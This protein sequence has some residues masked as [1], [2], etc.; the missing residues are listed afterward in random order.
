MTQLRPGA[1]G[2][3]AP[4]AADEIAV[5]R[6]SPRIGTGPNSRGRAAAWAVLAV[7]VVAAIA[8]AAGAG[9]A[10][11]WWATVAVAAVA[12]AYLAAIVFK[13]FVVSYGSA[14]MTRLGAD[15]TLPDEELPL[16]TV[17]VPLAG[18]S[19][20]GT[21][22]SADPVANLTADMSALDY[23]ADRLQVLL[24]AA[25]GAEYATAALPAHFEI[26]AVGS[27]SQADACA[28]GLARARGELCVVYEPGQQPERGQLRAAASSFTKL[29]AWV[30]G[31]RPETQT[32]NP[33]A[34]W[35][36][37]YV[38]AE[39]VVRSVLL[40]RGLERLQLP[41]PAGGF[42]CHYR[43]DALRRLGAWQDG[44]LAKGADIGVRIARRGWTVRVLGS[45]TGEEA[46]GRLGHWLRQRAAS[47]RDDYRSWLAQTRSAYRLWR[48]LGL[49]RFA[50]F[51][52]TTAL[53][54]Y[55]ALVNPL[56]WLLTL[57]WL[58][59]GSR[60]VAGVFPSAELYAV[61]AVM[62]LG[63]LLTAYSLMIGCMERGL[64]AGVRMMLLAPVYVALTS[65]AAYRALLPVNR[66][67]PARAAVPS[68]AA[69]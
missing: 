37:E 39:S 25:D 47:M 15:K 22:R 36:T 8:S 45:V 6:G 23:P 58:A 12:A 57:L 13:L 10:P 40:V 19:Q 2:V 17:L 5:H 1:A 24:L 34:N 64:F 32:Q 18:T 26:V 50:A 3:Q 42:S 7:I 21:G 38:A 59:G 56:L 27:P 20:S 51:Q 9:P 66:P 60:L 61:I 46:E 28:V 65:V 48:D 43:T 35:L 63:N 52:L 67:E 14:G 55:T 62:L 4:G 53:F 16:Y 30:V 69:S 11:R 31:V 33:H 41:V 44:D 54:T 68:A 49:L 29:P